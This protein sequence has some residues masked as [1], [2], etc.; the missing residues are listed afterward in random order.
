M[1]KPSASNQCIRRYI[2][3]QSL[4]SPHPHPITQ[5]RTHTCAHTV[6]VLVSCHCGVSLSLPVCCFGALFKGCSLLSQP[7][8]EAVL[9]ELKTVLKSFLSQGQVLKLEVKVGLHN[10]GVC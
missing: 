6:S 2:V 4:L 5:A 8:D 10:C 7:L 3:V 1:A 9:S